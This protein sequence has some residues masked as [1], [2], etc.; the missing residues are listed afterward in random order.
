[1]HVNTL[2]KADEEDLVAAEHSSTEYLSTLVIYI[3]TVHPSKRQSQS[4]HENLQVTAICQSLFS[5][6]MSDFARANIQENGA[7]QPG[8]CLSYHQISPVS[9]QMNLI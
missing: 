8:R 4:Y 1:M 7:W 9:Y 2:S 6:N 3:L 5:V